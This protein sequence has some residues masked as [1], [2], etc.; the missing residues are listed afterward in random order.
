[1]VMAL[2]G[3]LSENS[4]KLCSEVLHGPRLGESRGRDTRTS[5]RSRMR[6]ATAR[7]MGGDVLQW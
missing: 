5:T 4:E 3:E 6:V 1:V 7:S 2:P